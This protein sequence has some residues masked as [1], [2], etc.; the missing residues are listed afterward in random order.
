[1]EYNLNVARRLAAGALA[2][3]PL[4]AY[5]RVHA[6]AAAFRPTLARM[7]FALPDAPR[8]LRICPG[9]SPPSTLPPLHQHIRRQ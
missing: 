3:P 4:S 7:A 1:V 8:A 6:P 5:R 2:P 9:P